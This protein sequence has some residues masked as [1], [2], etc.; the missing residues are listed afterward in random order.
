MRLKAHLIARY[1]TRIMEELRK[2]RAA[3][4]AGITKA[5][6]ASRSG[7]ARRLLDSVDDPE[8]NPTLETL[9]KL[10]AAAEA[11]AAEKSAALRDVA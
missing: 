4:A 10:A 2:I 11:L 8:W 9:T 3:I 7:V 6:L 1:Q 5:D